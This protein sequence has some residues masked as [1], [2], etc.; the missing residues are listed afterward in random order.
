MTHIIV[1]FI[2]KRV[3]QFQNQ[4]KGILLLARVLRADTE[5]KI[6]KNLLK[7]YNF[8]NPGLLITKG[9]NHANRAKIM[10]LS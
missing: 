5:S 9:T 1:W 2:D 8:F 10:Y 7:N 3:A 6:M 4:L